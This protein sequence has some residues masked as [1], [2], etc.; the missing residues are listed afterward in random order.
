[1][2]SDEARERFDEAF[3]G[4]LSHEDELAFEAALAA[5]PALREEWESFLAT[6][7]EVRGLSLREDRASAPVLIEGV[8]RKLRV[9]SRGRFYRDR[10]A[11][12]GERELLVP[13]LLAVVA[14]VLVLAAWAGQRI[15]GVSHVHDEH[16]GPPPPSSTR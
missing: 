14:V 3:E 6:M 7:R 9:R 5:D 2:T 8:Q 12:V 13:V 15:V 16:D 10:F 1:M 11:T 4:E